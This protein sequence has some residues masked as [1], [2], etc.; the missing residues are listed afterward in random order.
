MVH[1]QANSAGFYTDCDKNMPFQNPPLPFRHS[2]PVYACGASVSLLQ[3][4]RD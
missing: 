3:N 2:F 4:I 1:T